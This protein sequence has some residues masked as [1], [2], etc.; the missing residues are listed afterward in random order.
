MDTQY[1]VDANGKYLGAWSGCAP[2]GEV[3]P[4]PLPPDNA[5][6]VWDFAT[7][8]WGAVPGERAPEILRALADLDTATVRPLRALLVSQ[9][10][11]TAPDPDDV[12]RLADLEASAVALRAELAEL[13]GS[14]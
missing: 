2:D 7:A 9:A 1:Y 12:A 5:A 6:Q 11:G 4:V 10:A 3:F 8:I 13:S 14:C